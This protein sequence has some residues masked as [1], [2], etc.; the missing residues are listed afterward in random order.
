MKEQRPSRSPE[1]AER[2]KLCALQF[3]QM[4]E[5]SQSIVRS[6]VTLAEQEQNT[7]FRQVIAAIQQDITGDG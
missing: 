4:L 6:L 5:G 3:S 2:V 7:D 1:F